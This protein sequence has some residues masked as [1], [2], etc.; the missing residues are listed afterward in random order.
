MQ[1][2]TR[3]LEST[4][5]AAVPRRVHL[6]IRYAWPVILGFLLLAIASAGYFTRHFA[7]STDSKQLL[8]SS[9]PWRQQEA[10]LNAQFP[11]RIDQL[12]AVIDAATPEAA[13]DAADALVNELASRPD[14][15][16][17]VSRPDSGEFFERNGILFLSVNEVR[18]ATADLISAEPFLGTLAADPTLRGVF[19]T[20]SQSLEGVRLGKAKLD[21]LTPALDALTNALELIDKGKSP[22]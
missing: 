15:I 9:L 21:S 17:K 10:M 18:R 1:S 2:V 11:Q 5:V 20:F 12:I 3:N 4:P 8:S 16:R 22:S 13:D 14:L 7:I 6:S 19:R